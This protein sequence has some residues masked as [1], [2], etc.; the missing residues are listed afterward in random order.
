LPHVL[1]RKKWGVGHE[2]ITCV[3]LNVNEDEGAS[4]G[5]STKSSCA[6][7]K[8]AKLMVTPGRQ[9]TRR[10]L[11]VAFNLDHC[12]A[13]AA[14]DD[15]CSDALVYFAG[16][17]SSVKAH[18]YRHFIQ[19]SK[20]FDFT[21]GHVCACIKK[22]S[23]CNG[24]EPA[25]ADRYTTWQKP[26]LYTQAPF[27]WI[28]VANAACKQEASPQNGKK[29]GGEHPKNLGKDGCKLA[30]NS[31]TGC[32]RVIYDT[33][34]G[35]CYTDRLDELPTK[36][37]KSRKQWTYWKMTAGESFLQVDADSTLTDAVDHD[38]STWEG[39]GEHAE[40][41]E[42]NEKQAR[43]DD[44]FHVDT[45]E[46]EVDNSEIAGE[47]EHDEHHGD[48]HDDHEDRMCDGR[49]NTEYTQI[50]LNYLKEIGQDTSNISLSLPASADVDA[51][52]RSG[53]T[54]SSVKRHSQS[55]IS[56]TSS[57][58]RRRRRS[59]VPIWSWPLSEMDRKASTRPVAP[60]VRRRRRSQSQA[61]TQASVASLLQ[62]KG[63]G[64]CIKVR[65]LA[66]CLPCLET[67]QCADGVC[68]P[69]MKKC[70]M[71]RGRV[72]PD[73]G[74]TRVAECNP[75]CDEA[76]CTSCGEDYPSNWQEPTCHQ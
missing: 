65:S 70:V 38:L 4:V 13:L 49:S 74:Q 7:E 29:V 5:R 45:D 40:F 3:G 33:D 75:P 41:V 53:L 43:L 44:A 32:N 47:E 59:E 25:A 12:K 56:N 51:V 52:T 30:C 22:N 6:N 8:C 21:E 48:E 60:A 68:D 71:S 23:C 64:A 63:T 76:Q 72:C 24:C 42:R 73:S 54:S 19:Q 35:I 14:R 50:A 67:I 61:A 34:T 46:D 62:K 27:T 2:R 28:L 31:I 58:T 16:D 10:G 57:A 1:A 11:P 26:Y 36:C 69:I 37:R 17:G 9:R 39:V 66:S 55:Q 15:E 20:Q 18:P